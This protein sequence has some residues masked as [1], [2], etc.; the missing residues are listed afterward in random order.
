MNDYKYDIDLVD[1]FNVLW[2]RKLFIIIPT[3]LI[4]FVVGI[5]SSFLPK[6]WEIDAIIQPSKYVIQT[7]S[8]SYSEILIADP[9]Q[10]AEQINKE[11]YNYLVATKLN[12]DVRK[13]PVI[14]AENLKNTHLVL[15]STREKEVE[16]AKL[17]LFALFEH[18][19]NE[20]DTKANIEIN[21]IDSQIKSNEIEKIRIEK[22]IDSYKNM[23]SI[24]KQRINDIEK[25]MNETRKRVV[26][27]EK[28]QQLSLKKQNRS[29][30]ESLGMLLYSNEIQ[31]SLRYHNSLNELLSS[32]KLEE[33]NIN[34][35]IKNDQEKIKE[36]ENRIDN[37][38]IRKGRIDFTQLVKEPTPSMG[39]VS[40]KKKLNILIASILSLAIFTM[41]AL[42]IENLKRRKNSLSKVSR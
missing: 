25:E 36:L 21:G 39:P 42:F 30:S 29:D 17:I 7:E 14:K 41:L 38:K 6:V 8:G 10:I 34:L 24:V 16:K 40:P 13:I 33:E 32:K 27:L 37:L 20:L 23:L 19:K 2:K 31:A 28:D 26:L 9:K 15:I 12:M 5:V 1:L 4:V 11:S 22:E 18:L 35:D 3:L